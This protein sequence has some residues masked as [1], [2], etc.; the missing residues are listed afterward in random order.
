MN[1]TKIVC[2]IGPASSSVETLEKMIDA[3]MNVARFNMS[4]G[5]H[6]SHKLLIDTV[7][8]AR[9]NKNKPIAIMIDTKG[10]EIRVKQFENGKIMLKEGD[11][12]TLT[13]KDVTGTNEHVSIT[14]KNLPK[15]LKKDTKILLN[16]GNIELRV[17][18][19]TT[20]DIVCEVVHGLSLIHI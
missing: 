16:D 9:Q 5:T 8:Q 13:T 10:P 19:I 20:T 17:Q 6:E 11:K 12:F 1:K 18:K 7:K 2:S 4:H 15:I 3:G 14:Y